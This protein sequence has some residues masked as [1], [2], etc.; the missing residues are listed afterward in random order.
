MEV[1]GAVMNKEEGRKN[2]SKELEAKWR[3]G[4]CVSVLSPLA[5]SITTV[6]LQN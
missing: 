6:S 2:V 1:K 4:V 3:S 5:R